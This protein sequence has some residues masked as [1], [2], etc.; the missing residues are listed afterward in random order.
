M[1]VVPY[2]LTIPEEF[3][4]NLAQIILKYKAN[5]LTFDTCF[6]GKSSSREETLKEFISIKS[7]LIRKDAI[8]ET[9]QTGF[10]NMFFV[11][12]NMYEAVGMI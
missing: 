6:T 5:S 9:M 12:S 1:I 8:R 4:N 11:P 7:L 3:L 10:Y 2:I